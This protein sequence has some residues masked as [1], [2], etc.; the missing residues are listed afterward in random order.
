MMK[1]IKGMNQ[2][3]YL[4]LSGILL[5]VAVTF[6]EIGVLSYVALVPFFL[7]VFNRINGGEYGFKT[8][9]LD[10]FI[11]F[12]AYYFIAFHWFVYFYPL[13]FAGLGNLE[14]A[15][16]VAIAWVGIPLVQASFSA[17]IYSL[18]SSLSRCRVCRERP[19]FVA[20]IISALFVVNEWT[21]TLT[22]A[23]I[24]WARIALSQTKMPI[25]MQAASLFGSYFLCFIIVLFNGLIAIVLL[26][27]DKRVIA[28]T[29]AAFVLLGNLVI[30]AVLYALP[31]QSDGEEV[32]IALVQGNLPSQE[33]GGLFF[34]GVLDRYEKNVREAAGEGAEIVFLPEGVFVRE[35]NGL[36]SSDKHGLV[37][38]SKAMSDLSQELGVTIVIGTLFKDVDGSVYNSISVFYPDSTSDLGAYSKIKLVP[39]GEFVPFE[40]V[41]SAVAP[42]L[43]MINTLP[44]VLTGGDKSDVFVSAKNENA[45]NVGTLMCFDSIYATLGIESVKSGAELLYIP[46]DDSWF[47]D[48][49][50]LDMHHSHNILRAVEQGR[51]T[52][53]CGNTGITSIVNDKGEVVEQMPIF[54]E[55]YVL[56]TVQPV[57]ARTLYSHIG[58][59]LVLVCAVL[60]VIPLAFELYFRKKDNK[61]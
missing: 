12:F 34:D 45:I 60:I 44:E 26:K 37:R 5:G 2:R 17:L 59:I 28:G 19:I 42:I 39:F 31:S 47:Y 9:Y 14:S 18:L 57:S 15:L 32:K 4:L 8:A 52:V 50:A 48:S 58:D 1:I 13:D 27:K 41:V 29:L 6:T 30:G 61:E 3:V 49:R 11:L 38:I 25:M 33:D 54:T 23:G 53:S 43:G 35:V 10:G 56:G 36:V 7:V 40:D 51:Y 21:Q 22:W 20:I 55:G 46:S 24:P 16:V